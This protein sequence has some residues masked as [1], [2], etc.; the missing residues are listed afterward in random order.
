MSHFTPPTPASVW[1]G[2]VLSGAVV[3]VLLADAL[4]NLV[5]P[6]QLAAEMAAT[7]FPIALARPLGITIL[8]CALAYAL[9]PT[10]VIGAILITAFA[11][12]AIATHFRL[13]EM[14][15]P[16]QIIS[17]TISVLAWAGLFLR[18]PSLSAILPLLRRAVSP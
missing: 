5:A 14:G 18:Y 12:G 16:A 6:A 4:V 3:V 2:R 11:G 1:T 10:S 15:S 9:P 7:G 17:V 13:G 8:A